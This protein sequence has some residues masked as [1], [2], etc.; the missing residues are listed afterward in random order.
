[1]WSVVTL[2][3][4]VAAMLILSFAAVRPSA[5]QAR[6]LSYSEPVVVNVSGTSLTIEGDFTQ[7]QRVQIVDAW[8]RYLVVVGPK[9][10]CLEPVTIRADESAKWRA[11]YRIQEREVIIQPSRFSQYA[12]THELGHHLDLSCGA[13]EELDTEF[14][15][16]Q[17]LGSTPWF[18]T[19]S[20]A[21]RPAEHFAETVGELIWG[22]R[23]EQLGISISAEAKQVVQSWIGTDMERA[24]ASAMLSSQCQNPQEPQCAAVPYDAGAFTVFFDTQGS[25]VSI[26]FSNEMIL[27]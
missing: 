18:Q 19:Q 6:E 25:I 10:E 24:A 5:A 23:P 9:I 27:Q 4:I 7:W 26:E 22:A 2:V 13:H 21:A 8:N 12:V 15:I 11:L 17:N 16:A 20:W 1:M 14:R 3:F